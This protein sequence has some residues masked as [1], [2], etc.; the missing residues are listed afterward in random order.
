MPNVPPVP[1]FGVTVLENMPQSSKEV[2]FLVLLVSTGFATLPGEP[3]VCRADANPCTQPAVSTGSLGLTG[4]HLQEVPAPGVLLVTGENVA[5]N[6]GGKGAQ[7]QE[8]PQT[9]HRPSQRAHKQG[10]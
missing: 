9:R 5:G 2:G 3:R 10:P 4:M 6:K 7:G 8:V 1:G